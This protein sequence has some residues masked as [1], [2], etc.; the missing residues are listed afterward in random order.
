V[1]KNHGLKDKKRPCG[2]SPHGLY[3]RT[4]R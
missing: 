4:Q 1:G 3:I 2:C